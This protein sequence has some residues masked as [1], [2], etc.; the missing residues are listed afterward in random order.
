MNLSHITVA[1]QS[2]YMSRLSPNPPCHHILLVAHVQIVT[3]SFLSPSESM[4]NTG[5][6]WE[7]GILEVLVKFRPYMVEVNGDNTFYPNRVPF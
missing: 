2:P 1:K 7:L 6:L 3:V 5:T 4:R